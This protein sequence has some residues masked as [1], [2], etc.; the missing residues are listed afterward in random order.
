MD[1]ASIRLENYMNLFLKHFIQK[2]QGK[3]HIATP[4]MF[5]VKMLLREEE[6]KILSVTN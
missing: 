5:F 2:M 3:I 1:V 6:V 4:F